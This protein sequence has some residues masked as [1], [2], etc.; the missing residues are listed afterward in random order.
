[1]RTIRMMAQIKD[2]KAE[3]LAGREKA[4]RI[5]ACEW[6]LLQCRH[7]ISSASHMMRL[8]IEAPGKWM[9]AELDG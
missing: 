8:W 3:W 5:A 9:K 6:E 7:R 4:Y 1:M 2:R